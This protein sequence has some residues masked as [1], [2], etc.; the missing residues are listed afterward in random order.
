MLGNGDRVIHSI[1]QLCI[2]HNFTLQYKMIV[3]LN[4]IEQVRF[5]HGEITEQAVV[6]ALGYITDEQL[7]V[8]ITALSNSKDEQLLIAW[9][10]QQEALQYQPDAVYKRLL[11]LVHQIVWH[12]LAP[13]QDIPAYA[14]SKGISVDILVKLFALLVQHEQEMLRTSNRHAYLQMLLL[15]VWRKLHCTVQVPQGTAAAPKVINTQQPVRNVAPQMGSRPIPV[16]ASPVKP[17]HSP[18]TGPIAGQ[19]DLAAICRQ[20]VAAIAPDSEPL[21]HSMLMQLQPISWNEQAKVL[22][23]SLPG[24]LSLFVDMITDSVA[25]KQSLETLVPGAKLVVQCSAGSGGEIPVPAIKPRTTSSEKPVASTAASSNQ[26]GKN[27]N[28]AGINK[29]EWP[30]TSMLLEEFSGTV[31]ELTQESQ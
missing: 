13:K 26:V 28:T 16:V 15:M 20:L 22:T 11:Q 4:V 31:Q 7:L 29:Q 9:V 8:L 25:I 1:P 6:N 10:Q 14:A 27:F 12:T 21:V 23:V 2:T 3:A 18:A 17:V 5:G 30:I 24:H 19:V